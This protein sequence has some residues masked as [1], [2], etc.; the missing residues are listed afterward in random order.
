MSHTITPTEALATAAKNV[1]GSTKLATLLGITASAV[2]Q[3]DRVP[4]ERV[5]DVEAAT[6]VSRYQLRPDI[7]GEQ[8][9][10]VLETLRGTVATEQ[11]IGSVGMLTTE[12]DKPVTMVGK[13]LGKG[14][15]N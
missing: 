14:R 2:S 8:P 6:G 11:A 4:A 1:G 13:D 7:Y 5:L 9:E 15:A 3:W 12:P 10:H